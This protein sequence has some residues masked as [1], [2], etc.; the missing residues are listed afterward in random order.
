MGHPDRIILDLCG[1]TGAWSK[2]YADA[3]YDVRIITKPESSVFDFV[4]SEPVYGI[5][6]APPCTHFSIARTS[7]ISPRDF[8]SAMAIV[9]QCLRIIWES[10]ILSPLAFWALENPKGYLR[11]FLG[12]PAYTFQPYDFGSPWS[13]P[14]DIWGKFNTDLILRP[15]Q[16]TPAQ[17]HMSQSA[18]DVYLPPLPKDYVLPPGTRPMAARR[19]MTPAGFAEAFMEANP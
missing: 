11:D 14:T 15:V 5:L 19:A 18:Y 7:A 17:R 3:G 4:V 2:P 9:G 13:K 8:R 6:A 12:L 16:M 10:Q 1:G